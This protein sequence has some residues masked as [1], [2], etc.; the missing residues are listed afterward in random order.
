[1]IGLWLR[2]VALVAALAPQPPG[3]PVF[4]ETVVVAE[5]GPRAVSEV[6]AAVS[7]LRAAELRGQPVQNL[8][9]WIE[10][11]PGFQ[12]LAASDFGGTPMVA[13]RG[14]FGG[15][16]AEY[17]Q[18]RV[19][20]FALYDPESGLAD[21]KRLRSA[22]L[23]ALEALHGA[24]SALYGDTALAGVIDVRTAPAAG[25]EASLGASL[26]SFATG[27][28]D[29]ALAWGGAV[30]TRI[31]AGGARTD[32][33]RDSTSGRDGSLTLAL[34]GALGAGHWRMRAGASTRRRADGGPLPLA[35][36]EERA[37]EADP[38]FADDRDQSD[39]RWAG[40]RW[41]WRGLEV[42][43]HGAHRDADIVRTLLLLP[44]LADTQHRVLS[45]EMAGGAVAKDDAFTLAGRPSQLRL[46]AEL[47]RERLATHYGEP[48]SRDAADARR[49][50][51]G[52][53]FSQGID[54]GERWRFVAGARWDRVRDRGADSVESHEAWSP[55]AGVVWQAARGAR[56]EAEVFA[57]VSRAFKTATLDQL[58]DPRPFPDF[59]GGT[60]H[61]SNP[62]LV[63]Q[64]ARTAEAGLRGQARGARWQ[65]AAYRTAVDDEIDFDPAT[66]TYRNI[67]A[68]LHD[69]LEASLEGRWRAWR[70][71][72]VYAWTRAA[73]RQGEA[74]GRQLK[75]V[76]RHLLRAGLGAERGA[77][78]AELRA[79]WLGGR[80]LDDFERVALAD[81]WICDA[82]V[83]RGFG[84]GG[85]FLDLLNATDRV[86]A[87]A[88]Y[89][90]TDLSG[91]PVPYAV[92]AAGFAA[93]AGFD[94]RFGAAP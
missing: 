42:E 84:R 68:S 11:L 90:L 81:V 91:A 36:L 79:S 37:G 71:S 78:T 46:G 76:P 92:P 41:D 47:A 53:Y 65:L 72:L 33:Y 13:A 3:A 70:P 63:P 21:W 23:D 19:D 22:S 87:S 32:G 56:G 82:R 27:T 5:R 52:A 6:P 35:V 9:E 20:G 62:Q 64:R 48:A 24:A 25:R 67:G 88:G 44:E 2:Q 86:Y 83:R 77:W 94:L 17:V 7:V 45:T 12:V 38:R 31:A 43:L 60:F 14:F 4:R 55:R 18:L 69:G 8:A 61:I 50:R 85:V 51:L 49:E 93:R 89:V 16:E 57:Q 30:P 54:L 75:N 29:A 40:A 80:F 73:P 34:D 74:A 66:F 15:G 59:A 1:M 26:G 10:L 58:F 28:A 39:R